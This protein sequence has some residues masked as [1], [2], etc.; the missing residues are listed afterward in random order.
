VT[1]RRA[2]GVLL[3]LICPA[4]ALAYRPFDQTDADV[5]RPREFEIELGT[6]AFHQEQGHDAL[7][8][9]LILNYGVAKRIEA[10]IESDAG[11]AMG[12]LSP[13]ITRWSLEP[14]VLLKGVLREGCLQEKTG[15]SVAVEA[16]LLLPGVPGLVGTGGSLAVIGSQ[17][18]QPGTLHLNLMAERQRDGSYDLLAGAIAEGPD[19]WRVRPVGE[20][21]FSRTATSMGASSLLAGAIWRLREE[22]ALDGAF[23]VDPTTV[24][25]GLEVRFGLTWTIPT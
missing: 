15:P 17:R 8:P 14:S 6:A 9:G 20:V 13:G 11:V 10:V 2:L 23:R 19:H 24:R 5:A 1:W 18:W 25:P 16:G 22:L 21:I 3:V 4:R 7:Q 12:T